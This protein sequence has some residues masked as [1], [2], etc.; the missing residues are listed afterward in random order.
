MQIKLV[1]GNAT[2]LVVGPGIEIIKSTGT[3]FLRVLKMTIYPA[4]IL[5]N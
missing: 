5:N 1:A 3:L 4:E 2:G